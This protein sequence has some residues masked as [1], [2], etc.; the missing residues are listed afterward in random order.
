MIIRSLDLFNFRNYKKESFVF[1]PGTNI[2]YG[3]NAQG[4]TN[5]L[6]ALFVGC[7]T[8]SHKGSKESELINKDG[9]EAHI[10]YISEK[11]ERQT[12][13]EIHL[14]KRGTK[15]IAIDG[16]P[17]KKANE[18]LGVCHVV[19]FSPEDLSIIKDGPEVRR[20]FI[21][22]E[23]CQLNKAYLYNINNLKVHVMCTHIVT[24]NIHDFRG[25]L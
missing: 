20:R 7:T 18:I 22:I 2:L 6:E 10:R 23:L 11:N 5:A 25:I 1:D 12:K 19:F 14:K 17:I 15:G 9:E 21:D 24:Q 16:L 13:V 3:D 4:K 8:K